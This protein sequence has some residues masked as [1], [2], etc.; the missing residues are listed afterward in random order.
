M[1]FVLTAAAP[2]ALTAQPGTPGRQVLTIEDAVRIAQER[3]ITV[4]LASSRVDNAGAHVTSSFGSFLPQFQ[5][6]ASYNRPL[7]ESTVYYQGVPV[8]GSRP[9]VLQANA[10][11]SVQLFD[12]FAR[13]AEY[14][15]AQ[16]NFN[17][18]VEELNRER[19]AVAFQTRSAFLAAL[20]AEQLIEVRETDLQVA[21]ESLA[22]VRGLVEAGVAQAGQIYAE[23]SAIA[24]AELALEQSRTDAIIA[25]QQLAFLMNV[26]PRTDLQLTDDGLANSVDSSDVAAAR[27]SLGSTTELYERLLTS[28]PDIQ[29]ARLRVEAADAQVTAARSSYYPSVGAGLGYNWQ[30]ADQETSSDASFGLNLQYTLFDGFRTSEQVQIAKAQMQTAQLEVRRLELQAQSELQTALAQL[31]GSD[32]QLRAAD[33]A[34]AAARQ[35]RFAAS[36]RYNAGVGTYTDVLLASAQYLTAQIN[37]VNAVYNFRLA[38]YQVRFQMGE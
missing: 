37:Q 28:R 24:N 33:R 26:D 32:R 5:V 9:D 30:S 10:N 35:N 12:G 18:S 15:S 27:A 13:T 2:L 22:R 8:P 19:Q 1:A 16:S 29:A 38:V 34:V 21:R 23:E 11:A 6:N 36:E 7:T 4:A 14:S 3:N 20:R 31:E 25:R 17:A